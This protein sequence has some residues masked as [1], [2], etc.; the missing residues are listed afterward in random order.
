MKVKK[1]TNFY[2]II[3]TKRMLD[4]LMDYLGVKIEKEFIDDPMWKFS[5][6]A[7]AVEKYKITNL[8][9]KK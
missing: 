1:E 6:P 8:K 5:N 9:K 3:E 4:C 2:Y 7:P